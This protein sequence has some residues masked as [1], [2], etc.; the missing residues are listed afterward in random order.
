MQIIRLKSLSGHSNL[1]VLLTLL[2]LSSLIHSKEALLQQILNDAEGCREMDAFL[3]PGAPAD[4]DDEDAVRADLAPVIH[5]PD[6][7]GDDDDGDLAP[8]P[9]RSEGDG[10]EDPDGTDGLVVVV[11][12]LDL[13]ITYLSSVYITVIFVKIP[14]QRLPS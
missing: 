10:R 12:I 11:V 2:Y 7:D 4:A 13:F 9:R 14:P 3:S 5:L 6:N 8:S 1:Y